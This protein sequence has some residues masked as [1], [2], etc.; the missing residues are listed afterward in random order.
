MRVMNDVFRPFLDKFFIV[1]LDDIL[2]FSSNLE[3]HVKNVKQVFDVL[4]REKLYLK[5]SKGEFGE[6]YL[7]YIGY[8]VGNG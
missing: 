7:I 4:Q 1:Y 6:N 3:E 5:L 2:I 8:I